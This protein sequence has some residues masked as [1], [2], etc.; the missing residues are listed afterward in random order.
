[1]HNIHC[2]SDRIRS[3]NKVSVLKFTILYFLY[4]FAFCPV[5]NLFCL[6]KNAIRSLKITPFFLP[7]LK[8]N[9]PNSN[10]PLQQL[11]NEM[12][13]CLVIRTRIIP[14]AEIV[15]L[16][17][18]YSLIRNNNINITKNN[19]NDQKSSIYGTSPAYFL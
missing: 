5:I 7:F 16:S 9:F 10:V 4:I 15:D 12:R 19:I 1:M 14:I 18:N 17:I 11:F 8:F 6:A 3:F 13:Y 2:I